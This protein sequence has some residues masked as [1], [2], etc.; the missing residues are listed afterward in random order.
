MPYAERGS[1][2]WI[3]KDAAAWQVFHNGAEIPQ[4]EM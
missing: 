3:L 1:P 4:T 2:T